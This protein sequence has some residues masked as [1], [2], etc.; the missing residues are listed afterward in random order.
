MYLTSESLECVAIFKTGDAFIYQL[1]LDTRQTK[2]ADKDIISL[3]HI[4]T[5][6]PAR[7]HPVLM[8]P[9]GRGPISAF[10]ASD[11]GIS[12]SFDPALSRGS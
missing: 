12:M 4:I 7:Y 2:P 11:I 9:S 6:A 8:I 3:T 1:E 5:P 10:G